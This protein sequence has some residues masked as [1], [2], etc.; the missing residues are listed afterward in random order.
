MQYYTPT[1]EE[2]ETLRALLQKECDYILPEDVMDEFIGLGKVYIHDKWSNIISDGDMNTNVYIA[3]EGILRCYFWD[4][5][6]EKTAFFSTLPTLFMSYHTYFG[7]IPSFY[8]FQTCTKAK[9]LH[10][11]REDFNALLRRSHDF[12]LWNLRLCQT[13]LFYFELKAKLNTGP[14]KDRYLSLI[15]ELPHILQEVPLQIVAS[16]LGITPQ[17]LSKLRKEIVS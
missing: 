2:R 3:M 11:R 4:G 12:A 15:K 8:S 1:P 10:I 14:A 13:Q 6:R 7:N 9:L 16:Y 17:Y 5:D